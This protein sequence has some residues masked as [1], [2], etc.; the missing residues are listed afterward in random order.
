[1]SKLASKTIF[2]TGASRGIG[3]AIALRCA[4][5]GANIVIASK[6]ST[7]HKTLP[8]TIHS[9]AKEVEEAGGKALALVLDVRDDE[10]VEATIQEAAEHFGGIDAVINN[11][12]AINLT[13]A[14][15]TPMKRVDLM[16]NVN[17]RAAYSCARAAI[18][19]LKKSD[20][21]HILSLSPP[22][23]L[24]PRW[25][26]NHTAYTISK[27]GMS[28]VTIGLAAELA[29]YGIS[30]HSLW[31]RTIIQ[32]DALRLVGGMALGQQGRTPEIMADAAYTILTQD[33]RDRSGECLI[34]ED[35][36]RAHG[37]TN[38]DHYAVDPSKKLLTDLF[39]DA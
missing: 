34:D 2:I 1:M 32:T 16:F 6:T 14:E 17:V 22:I 9:V 21:G 18:P 10:R 11:A 33:N 24:N 29:K 20:N 39:L 27:Y 7:P 3:R 31:P 35:I 5:D 13:P 23:N 19:W 28:M 15:H 36:L 25:F 38:F 37:Q 12:G 30:V 8:G 26:Q 4:A